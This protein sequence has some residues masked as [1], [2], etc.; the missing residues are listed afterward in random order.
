V[1]TPRWVSRKGE[2]KGTEFTQTAEY[3]NW[4]STDNAESR[5]T[6]ED[7]AQKFPANAV[8][9]IGDSKVEKGNRPDHEPG[10]SQRHCRVAGGADALGATSSTPFTSYGSSMLLKRCFPRGPGAA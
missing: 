8:D 5:A 6:D 2:C 9:T 1:P 7:L 4:L 10:E 3:A